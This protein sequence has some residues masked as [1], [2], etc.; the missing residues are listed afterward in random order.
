[1]IRTVALLTGLLLTHSATA[2]IYKW[3]DADGRVHFADRPVPGAEEI[4]TGP[5]TTYPAPPPPTPA[6][7]TA[8]PPQAGPAYSEFRIS[9]PANDATI[10]DNTGSVAVQ[11]SIEPGLRPGHAIQLLLDGRALEEPLT[12]TT[13]TLANLDRGTHTLQAAIVDGNG[14]IITRTGTTTVH[15]RRE[16]ILQPNKQA[17]AN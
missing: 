8:Q 11:L 1:M 10:R 9:S 5:L 6:R 2:A 12:T 7:T 16:S 15:L 14:A 17:P 3:T 13:F 4:R